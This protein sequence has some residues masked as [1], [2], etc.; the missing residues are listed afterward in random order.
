MSRLS[1]LN[2]KG[3]FEETHGSDTRLNVSSRSSQRLHYVSRDDGQAYTIISHDATAAAGTYIIYLQNTSSTGL[4][5][6][7]DDIHV[8]AVET[9]L[10][11]IWFVTG[12]ASGGSALTAVNLNKTSSNA[13]AVAARGDDAITNLTTDGQIGAIRVD[14]NGEGE[15]HFEDGLILGQNDAIAIEID[16]DDGSPAIAG[17][18]ITFYLETPT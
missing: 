2:S 9:S 7:V 3:Q 13:A 11:K 6:F 8:E 12:T 17:A 16:T 4:A 18:S 1:Y 14:A 5:L 10:F 15:K